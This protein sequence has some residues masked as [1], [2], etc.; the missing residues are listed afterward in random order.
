MLHVQQGLSPQAS[1]SGVVSLAGFLREAAL[2]QMG[3]LEAETEKNEIVSVRILS[4]KMFMSFSHGVCFLYANLVM[5][6][7]E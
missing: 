5:E 6:K 4:H 1:G 3:A 2:L 7:N